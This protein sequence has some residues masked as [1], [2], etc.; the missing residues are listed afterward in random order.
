[1]SITDRNFSGRTYDIKNFHPLTMLSL[2]E[3]FRESMRKIT[4]ERSSRKCV[5]RCENLPRIRGNKEDVLLL[6]E[7]MIRMIVVDNSVSAELYLYIDCDV[8][9]DEKQSINFQEGFKI[10]TIKFRTN[11]SPTKDWEV[12]HDEALKR[13]RKIVSDLNAIFLV[14]SS[15]QNGCMFSITIPGKN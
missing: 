1:M 4:A 8:V 15:N 13:C 5:T 12:R 6:F 9:N 7:E 2:N 14:N 3:I 10:Y 11:V